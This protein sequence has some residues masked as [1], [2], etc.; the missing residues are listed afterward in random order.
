MDISICVKWPRRE[1]GL[2]RVSWPGSSL[3]FAG[4][5][6]SLSSLSSLFHLLSSRLLMSRPDIQSRRKR[7]DTTSST[8]PTQTVKN[9]LTPPECFFFLLL[10][11]L[12]LLWKFGGRKMRWRGGGAKGG[13]MEGAPLF[14]NENR[15]LDSSFFFFFEHPIEWKRNRTR[16]RPSFYWPWLFLFCCR[17]SH[18]LVLLPVAKTK[19]KLL[20][21]VVKKKIFNPK[22]ISPECRQNRNGKGNNSITRPQRARKKKHYAA[23]DPAEGKKIRR[24]HSTPAAA[25]PSLAAM[26]RR[27]NKSLAEHSGKTFLTQRK[28]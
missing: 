6:F 24:V 10:L 26:G 27:N 22:R 9:R 7:K 4:F 28:Q 5:F 13:K 3:F 12:L 11:L 23:D 1:R 25:G 17:H 14:I 21:V 19:E 8:F 15:T 18:H 16:R 20:S 2:S